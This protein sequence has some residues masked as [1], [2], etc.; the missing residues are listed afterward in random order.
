MG[1]T[2]QYMLRWINHQKTISHTLHDLLDLNAFTD[3]TLACSDDVSIQAHRLVLSACSPFFRSILMTNQNTNSHPIIVMNDIKSSE[4]RALLTYMYCGEV[5]V[6]SED[7]K[8]IL[9]VA[10]NLQIKGL[11]NAVSPEPSNLSTKH[12]VNEQ[13]QAQIKKSEPSEPENYS[14]TD[15]RKVSKVSDYEPSCSTS[16]AIDS[17]IRTHS[18]SIYNNSSMP[19]YPDSRRQPSPPPTPRSPISH[20]PTPPYSSLSRDLRSFVPPTSCSDSRSDLRDQKDLSV[21]RDSRDHFDPIPR[22]DSPQLMPEDLRDPRR[23][24]SINPPAYSHIFNG[25]ESPPYKRKRNALHNDSI[26]TPNPL[27]QGLPHY[28][29]LPHTLRPADIPSLMSSMMPLQGLLNTHVPRLF[30]SEPR[31]QHEVRIINNTYKNLHHL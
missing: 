5:N 22:N 9:K 12:H 2:S 25:P 15:L 24:L 27:L 30:S 29:H 10:E 14:A 20:Y 16:S 19:F 26:I 17:T 6:P 18:P 28:P 4:I 13:K 8:S 23:S 11:E 3:V 21:I 31:I 1:S 7:L